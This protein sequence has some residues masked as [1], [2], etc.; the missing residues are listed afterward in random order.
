MAGAGARVSVVRLRGG[1]SLAL[2]LVAAVVATSAAALSAAKASASELPPVQGLL[3]R[4]RAADLGLQD[5]GLVASWAD[6]VGGV[7]VTQPT[8]AR[9]P[10]FRASVPTLGGQP[11]VSFSRG[12]GQWLTAA[13]A[14]ATVPADY[15]AGVSGVTVFVVMTTGTSTSAATTSWFASTGTS[16]SQA[17]VLDQLTSGSQA[18]IGARRLDTD[19]LVTVN[20]TASAVAASKPYVITG[21]LDFAGNQGRQYVNGTFAVA[22]ALSGAGTMSATGSRRVAIGVN[23]SDANALDGM[24]SEILVYRSALT[25]QERALVHSYVQDTYGIAVSDYLSSPTPSTTTTTSTTSSPT[26]TTSSP[27]TT[28]PTSST[29]ST[30]PATTSVPAP[31]PAKVAAPTVFAAPA[32]LSAATTTTAA[33]TAKD[34]TGAP[35]PGAQVFLKFQATT[36]GGTASVA[37][38]PLT[39]DYQGFVTDSTGQVVVSYTTPAVIARG[40]R[41]LLTAANLKSGATSTDTTTYSFTTTKHW[42]WAPEP[43][44]SPG[45]LPPGAH[46]AVS[47]TALD[48]LWNP[49]PDAQVCLSLA[50]SLG[51]GSAT[52]QGTAL[53]SKYQCVTA[54]SGGTAQIDYRTPDVLPATGMDMLNVRDTTSSLFNTSSFHGYSFG[55]LTQVTFSPNPIAVPGEVAPGGKVTVTLTP[56]DQTGAQVAGATVLLWLETS[57]GSKAT[58]SSYAAA[59]DGTSLGA[60]PKTFLTHTTTKL[61]ISYQTS[62]TRPASGTDQIFAQVTSADGTVTAVTTAEYT[63]GG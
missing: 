61:T 17:R 9:Q 47:V 13:A 43:T 44:G 56:R 32:T 16:D 59:P 41:D 26:T 22:K 21:L 53:T 5:G 19:A 30:T 50:R 1:R 23:G 24:V 38:V 57:S 14:S 60:T 35:M 3:S 36:G 55:Q 4:W 39:T 52:A 12:T 48:D 54:D 49:V 42:L 10:V 58:V 51:G 25:P 11:A 31:V 62:K 20:S 40:G 45:S 8:T 34:A 2:V 28:E 15:L 27:T 37:G 33:V 29:S 18:S 46:V 6:T 7:T 63:W